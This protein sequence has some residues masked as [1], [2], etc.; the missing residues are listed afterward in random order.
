MINGMEIWNL[1]PPDYKSITL[2]TRS[3]IGSQ[4]YK[5]LN[6]IYLQVNS[7]NINVVRTSVTHSAA[8][9]LPLFCSYHILTSSVIYY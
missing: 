8:P 5:K 7:K 2:A 9:R 4:F 3:N 1:E 6:E